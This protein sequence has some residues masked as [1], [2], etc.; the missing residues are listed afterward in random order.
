MEIRS[1]HRNGKRARGFASPTR[2]EVTYVL[3]VDEGVASDR[4]QEF[5]CGYGTPE[6]GPV[7]AGPPKVLQKGKKARVTSDL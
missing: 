7:E 6:A 4:E 3:Y 5:Q 2:R 1:P